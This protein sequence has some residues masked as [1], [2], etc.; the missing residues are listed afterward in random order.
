MKRSSSDSQV[1][2]SI[3][4]KCELSFTTP[5]Y[6]DMGSYFYVKDAQAR[7]LIVKR[8]RAMYTSLAQSAPARCALSS[9]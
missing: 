4:L 3:Q 9:G 2:P 5:V 8:L 1:H 6:G 7:L